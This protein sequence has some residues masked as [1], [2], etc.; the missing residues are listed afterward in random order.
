LISAIRHAQVSCRCNNDIDAHAI[1]DAQTL[2]SMVGQAM[3]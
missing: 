3:R 1:H 2:K